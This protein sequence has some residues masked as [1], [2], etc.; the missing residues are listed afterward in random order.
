MN[1][2]FPTEWPTQSWQNAE[3]QQVGIN[4]QILHELDAVL[5]PS[6]PGINAIHIV[7]HGRVVFERYNNG[8]SPDDPLNVASVTKSVISALVGIAIDKGYIG[9]LDQKVL[10]FFPE[11]TPP[12]G[13]IQKRAVTLR[14]LLTMTTP[15]AWKS[16]AKGFEPL[17]RLRRQKNWVRFILDMLGERGQLGKFQ[18][19]SAGTHLLSA[20]LTRTTGKPARA[21]A[22]ETLF[23]PLG[24]RQIPEPDMSSFSLEEVFGENMSGWINDP[25]GN[26]T[27]GWGLTITAR[28]LSRLGYLYLNQGVWNGQQIISKTWIQESTADQSENYG[29]LWWRRGN[30]V[31]FTYFAAGYG[32]SYLYCTPG[33]DLVVTIISK[34]G[35]RPL[36]RWPIMEDYLFPAI[37]KGAF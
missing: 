12:P 25:N 3:P 9:S 5:Q 36:D 23:A 16:S 8:K 1:S 29:Y 30:G 19:S 31:D 32:G 14:H 18:Y 34:L 22:N 7:R 20:I 17:D 10:E 37:E 28:D 35:A 21:F 4:P 11:Y 26:T 24:M 27:G 13:A 2:Q 15:F 6:Y 33:K